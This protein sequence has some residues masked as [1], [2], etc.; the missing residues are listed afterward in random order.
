MAIGVRALR[1]A[2]LR[3]PQ[4]R[5]EPTDNPRGLPDRDGAPCTRPVLDDWPGGDLAG[6][7]LSGDGRCRR[8]P[9][10]RPELHPSR[11]P[12]WR[13]RKPRNGGRDGPPS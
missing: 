4:D 12:R 8:L 11:N 13:L 3:Q 9:A 5:G 6:A 1:S 10:A 7:Q 2:W